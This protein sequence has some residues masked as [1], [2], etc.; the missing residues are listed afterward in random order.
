MDLQ[1][2]DSRTQCMYVHIESKPD[3]EVEKCII[4]QFYFIDIKKLI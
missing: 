3:L 2:Y 4:A 1:L